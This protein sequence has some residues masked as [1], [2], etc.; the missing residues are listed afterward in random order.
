M[1]KPVLIAWVDPWVGWGRASGIHQ[2]RA[3]SQFCEV[4]YGAC[5]SVAL[6]WGLR[7]GTMASAI[8][9]VWEKAVT[10]LSPWCQALQFLPVCHWCLSSSC[11]SAG[12]Q[13]EWRTCA[14]PLKGTAW[15]FSSFFW[16]LNPCWFLQPKV[17]ETIF[18]ALKPSAGEA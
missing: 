18:L 10:H 11:P 14:G 12:A 5:C 17:M 15:E 6:W 2:G 3:K 7:K 16:R 1:E 9:S 8:S 4:S 13:I